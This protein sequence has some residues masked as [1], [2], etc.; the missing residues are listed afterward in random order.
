MLSREQQELADRFARALEE[1]WKGVEYETWE[2]GCP[3]L[4][5]CLANLECEYECTHEG[6]DHVIFVGRVQRMTCV[7][8]REPLIFFRGNYGDIRS[9]ER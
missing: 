3:I 1:K 4:P 5:G 7:P 9:G 8:T 6:G 2:S